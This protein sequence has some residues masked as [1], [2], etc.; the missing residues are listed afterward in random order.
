MG[1]FTDDVAYKRNM[2]SI[3]EEI[4]KSQPRNY[5]M[6]QLL[7]LG[8]EV[9]RNNWK[10]YIPKFFELNDESNT[11]PDVCTKVMD[12]KILQILDKKWTHSKV[13]SSFFCLWGSILFMLTQ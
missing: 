8:I 10:K 13:T 6:N 5:I 9:I 7:K 2:E 12:F 11:H 1:E 3:L 4:K